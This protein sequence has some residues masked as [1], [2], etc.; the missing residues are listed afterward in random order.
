MWWRERKG[1][2][3]NPGFWPEHMEGWIC[4]QNGESSRSVR[5]GSRIRW[6]CILSLKL[7][8]CPLPWF[9]LTLS[10]VWNLSGK[11]TPGDSISTSHLAHSQ[12]HPGFCS[13]EASL[14]SFLMSFPPL[15]I[16]S[17][18]SGYIFGISMH[19]VGLLFLE[20]I[21]DH[22]GRLC[23]FYIKASGRSEGVCACIFW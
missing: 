3:M 16:C 4:C 17:H 13:T 8:Y 14:I 6:L 10:I 18:L 21:L 2:R 23:F 1:S 11:K 5:W 7:A 15:G 12:P 19:Q 20:E 9:L 22:L